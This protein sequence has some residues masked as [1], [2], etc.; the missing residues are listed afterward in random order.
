MQTGTT[1]YRVRNAGLDDLQAVLSLGIANRAHHDTIRT[2]YG[3]A[4]IA[5]LRNR[6]LRWLSGDPDGKLVV[7]EDT[8][9]QRI[10]GMA[11]G[12]LA[13]DFANVDEAYVAAAHRRRGLC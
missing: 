12:V 8:G 11:L 6:H 9:E 4:G 7:A 10:V 13:R 5:E 3:A 2:G 1:G